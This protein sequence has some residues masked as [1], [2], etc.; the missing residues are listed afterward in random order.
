[1]NK[2][3]KNKKGQGTTEYVLIIGVIV[4][5]LLA[6]FLIFRGKIETAFT[7]MG[8]AVDNVK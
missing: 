3:L 1:M 7:R 6:A 4:I 2:L 5:F 8:A